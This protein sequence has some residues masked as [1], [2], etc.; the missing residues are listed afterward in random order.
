MS[1]PPCLTNTSLHRT[2]LG[3]RR[4]VGGRVTLGLNHGTLSKK[5]VIK[6]LPYPKLFVL[7]ILNLVSWYFMF[8]NMLIHQSNMTFWR[9]SILIL[10]H[11]LGTRNQNHQRIINKYSWIGINRNQNWFP[12]CIFNKQWMVTIPMSSNSLTPWRIQIPKETIRIQWASLAK[13]TLNHSI[14]LS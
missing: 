10:A 4:S 9:H 1:L 2:N 7:P 8:T 3:S 6:M 5:N 11:D 13:L 12:L 14:S